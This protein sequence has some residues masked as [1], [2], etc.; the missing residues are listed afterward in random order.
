MLM[1][2]PDEKSRLRRE[3]KAARAQV[4]EDERLRAS[5][6]LCQ[7]LWSFVREQCISRVGVYLATRTEISLDPLIERLLEAGIEVGA[8]RIE[9][10]KNTMGFF[11]LS[12]LSDVHIGLWNLR[13]PSSDDEIVPPLVLVP[14]V[15]FDGQGHRLGMGAGYYDRF[16][17]PD[18][19]AIGVG[20]DWQIVPLVPIEDHD[21]PMDWVFSEK[22]MLGP[23]AGKD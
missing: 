13:E 4:G 20:Y 23:F 7:R 3:M 12:A 21:L 14:G 18:M 16:L 9:R 10:E 2:L 11:R 6:A 8:P 1:S 19:V 22:Q 5:F 17:T 15:A